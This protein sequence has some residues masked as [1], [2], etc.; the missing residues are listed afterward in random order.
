[1][2]ENPMDHSRQLPGQNGGSALT[3]PAEVIYRDQEPLTQLVEAGSGSG[4]VE[5]WRVVVRHKATVLLL[6]VLGGLAG[7]LYTLPE[8]P[9]YR[10]HA[11]IEVQGLNENF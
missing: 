11:T 7:F 1:M 10:A 5:Y 3:R 2:T 4:L 6:F 9:I 8:T